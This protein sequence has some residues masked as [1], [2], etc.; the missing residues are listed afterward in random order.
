[1]ANSGKNSNTSQFYITLAATPQ[2]DGKHVVIGRVMQGDEVLHR[3]SARLC[4][5][6]CLRM[7]FFRFVLPDK[8]VSLSFALPCIAFAW[9]Q[10]A[11]SDT[12]TQ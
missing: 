7:L 11:L 8:C 1:M 2:C 9:P 3:I 5:L 4:L 10:S 6:P 12:V